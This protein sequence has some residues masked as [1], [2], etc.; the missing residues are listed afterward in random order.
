VKNA[1]HKLFARD[2]TPN[3]IELATQFL[4]KPTT[5]SMSRWEQ[6][7]QVLLASDE[8]LYVD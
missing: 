4:S 8:M 6:Y 5:S 1:Y 7:A 3:E 2:A